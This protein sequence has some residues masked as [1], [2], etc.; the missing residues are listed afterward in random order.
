MIDVAHDRDHRRPRDFE[1][2]GIRLLEQVFDGFVGHLVFEADDLG[3]GAELA[4]DVLHQ[5]RIERLIDR[6][7]NAAHQQSCDQIFA[8]HFELLGEIL[9][10]DAF[11]HRD[12]AGDRH[13]LAGHLQAA[14]TW[15]RLEALHRA[16]FALF[17]APVPPRRAA[18]RSASA[19][20]EPRPEAAPDRPRRRVRDAGQ[21]R[22]AAGS[23]A[24]APMADVHPEVHR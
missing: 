2:I 4:G 11:G 13:R 17:V 15:W 14:K 19:D 1:L 21:T 12:G 16:F 18:V 10:A 9:D 23:R 22:D 7:E 3:V 5:F 24:A 8:A 20:A 6:D